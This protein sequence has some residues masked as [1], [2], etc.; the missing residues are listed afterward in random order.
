VDWSLA[1]AVAAI[2]PAPPL[3]QRAKQRL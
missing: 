1:A 2:A 3:R